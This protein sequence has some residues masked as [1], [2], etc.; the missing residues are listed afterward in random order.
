MKTPC[1]VVNRE[2]F[3]KNLDDIIHNFERVW[4]GEVV[5]GY[6]V[7]TNNNPQMIELAIEN[8]MYAEVVS[9]SEYNLVKRLGFMHNKIIFNGPHKGNLVHEALL[10]GAIV[11]VDN[12]G[13]LEELCASFINY[14]YKS[15]LKIG[16]RINFDLEQKVPGQT[17][18][19]NKV[20][21]FGI[22]VENGD[23]DRA[24]EVM[25]KYNFILKGLHVH[26]TTK[27]R[28]VDVYKAIAREMK[29]LLARYK[30]TLEYVDFGGGFFGGLIVN[31]KPRMFDYA[32]AITEE[33][34]GLELGELMLILEPGSSLVASTVD[35]IT[36]IVGK[37]MIRGT[38]ICIVDGS[39]LHINPFMRE[40]IPMYELPELGNSII[41]RQEVCGAT[42]LENDRLI[43][44]ENCRELN[45]GDRIKFKNTGAYTMS[46]ASNF[47]IQ[48][49]KVYIE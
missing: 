2:K 9:E 16:I 41:L 13:E 8:N 1:Y 21:R 26:Y 27:S 29:K 7:K 6:S 36:T 3:K 22:C 25:R 34:K 23:L 10:K 24:I 14:P 4:E 40:R 33:L 38:C 20:G 5:C 11:N 42:C 32:K 31:D 15:Q 12:L 47:I 48:T 43:I 17:A 18:T 49:P 37:K 39:N 35:Y 28:S 19:G 46:F 44:L 45:I 30:D